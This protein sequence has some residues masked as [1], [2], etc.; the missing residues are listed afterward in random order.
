MCNFGGVL[1]CFKAPQVIPQL[2]TTSLQRRMGTLTVPSRGAAG[3]TQGSA[4][5]EDAA[6]KPSHNHGSEEAT[7]E[8]REGN[9]GDILILPDSGAA[10][11]MTK[12]R[13]EASVSGELD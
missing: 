12:V 3:M 10:S 2:S 7:I 8:L 4:G 9:E 5:G 6:L 1:V 11:W 13:T